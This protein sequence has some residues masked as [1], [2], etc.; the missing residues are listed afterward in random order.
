MMAERTIFIA[1][2]GSREDFEDPQWAGRAENPYDPDVSATGIKEAQQ[3]ARR[4]A[5]EQ[6]AYLY[7]STYLR[8]VRTAHLC[9]EALGL[10]IRIEAGFGE[11]R[12]AEWFARPP[13]TRSLRELKEQFPMVDESYRSLVEPGFPESKSE[14]ILRF[15]RTID[16]TLRRT[17]GALLIV[18]HGATVEGIGMSLLPGSFHPSADPASLCRLDLEEGSWHLRFLND[19]SHLDASIVSR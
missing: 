3:L 7:S 5:R 11:W 6:I 4:M 17:A 12:N 18:G 2:H 8:A 16:E 14:S 15:G 1:R 10:S 9:A 13:R 19:T